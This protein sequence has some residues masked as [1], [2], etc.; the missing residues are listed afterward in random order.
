M[1]VGSSPTVGGL[2]KYFLYS[3]HLLRIGFCQVRTVSGAGG[4]LEGYYCHDDDEE[5]TYTG[6]RFFFQNLICIL[7]FEKQFKKV[8]LL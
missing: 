3:F 7:N 8:I 2:L 1:V 5:A 4:S 6:Q